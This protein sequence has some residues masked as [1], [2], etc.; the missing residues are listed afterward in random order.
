MNY[1]RLIKKTSEKL[2]HLLFQKVSNTQQCSVRVL[3]VAVPPLEVMFVQIELA[4]ELCTLC[5][6]SPSSNSHLS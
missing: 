2:G 5:E 6:E 3:D 4:H 1:L